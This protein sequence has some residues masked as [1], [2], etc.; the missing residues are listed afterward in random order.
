MSKPRILAFA[1]SARKDSY[2]RHLVGVASEGA[3]SAGVE[4]TTGPLCSGL[5]SG[6]GMAISLKQL[7]ARMGNEELFDQRIFVVSG[8]GCNQAIAGGAGHDDETNSQNHHKCDHERE[9]EFA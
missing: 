9:S 8:D 2:N 5:A 3:R 6:V 7:A 4:V 1:G